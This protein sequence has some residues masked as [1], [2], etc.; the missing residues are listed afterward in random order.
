LGVHAKKRGKDYHVAAK[1]AVILSTGGIMAFDKTKRWLQNY[2]PDLALCVPAGDISATGD[3]YCMGMSC[4]AGLAGMNKGALLPS[5][6]LPGHKMAGIV[7]ANIWGLP[8]IYVDPAGNRFVNESSYYVLVSEQMIKKEVFNAYCIFDS[9]TIAKALEMVPKGIEKTRTLALGLD[10]ENLD[11]GIQKG[12][13]WKGETPG[14]LAKSLKIEPAVLEKTMKAYNDNA[15]TGKD[16]EFGRTKG[17][18]PLNA[19]PYYAFEIHLGM[20]AHSGGLKINEKSQVIDTFDNAIPGLYAAG[21][22]AIGIFGGRYPGS[23]GAISCLVT[24]GR[25][26]GRNAAAEKSRKKITA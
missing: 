13:V 4:G 19:P 7:Y 26:A 25:L 14:Q 12:Y 11:K 15:S 21:R 1:K 16:K 6:M 18:A 2:S 10:P 23:G 9:N 20:V 8:N 17:L 3:G 22:D 24:F 5:I